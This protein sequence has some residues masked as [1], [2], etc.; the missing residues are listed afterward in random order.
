M[1]RDLNL[2][3]D[4]L[5]AIEASPP[6]LDSE[7]LSIPGRT[8]E[9]ISYHCWLLRDARLIE[10][11][12]I[13][14]L[15]SGPNFLIQ[16]LTWDGHEFLDNARDQQTWINTKKLVEQG[17]VFSFEA[18]KVAMSVMIKSGIDAVTGNPTP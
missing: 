8:K 10:A 6:N 1:Q 2:I 3:R 18:I 5:L 11:E 9:E 13:T 15:D 4:L 12:E 14:T 16:S 17:K 7:E